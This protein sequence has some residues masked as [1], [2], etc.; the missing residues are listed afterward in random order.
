M[1]S[2]HVCFFFCFVFFCLNTCF[3]CLLPEA[4]RKGCRQICW[5]LL[6]LS[7][8]LIYQS[9]SVCA[10]FY[11]TL[12][13]GVFSPSWFLF[14]RPQKKKK[15]L[16]DLTAAHSHMYERKK[17]SV[18]GVGG[19][20]G[21][22]TPCQVHVNMQVNRRAVNNSCL[23]LCMCCFFFVF[24]SM[25]SVKLIQSRCHGLVSAF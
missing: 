18:V 9:A 5:Q 8:S 15:K 11:L 14:P 3:V 16:I 25:L 12:F 23:L 10:P 1:N 7:D 20:T 19:I 24:F 21:W 13:V 6:Y 17:H 4:E 2:I 22:L